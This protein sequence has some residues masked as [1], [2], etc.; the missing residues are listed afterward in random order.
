ML[1]AVAAGRRTASAFPRFLDRYGYDVQVYQLLS[2]LPA[3][4]ALIPDVSATYYEIAYDNGDM[5]TGGRI[6][7]RMTPT[8]PGCRAILHRR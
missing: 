5:V 1:G 8:S 3:T 2:P 6:G 4:V 7:P